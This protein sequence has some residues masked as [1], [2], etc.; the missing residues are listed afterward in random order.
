M[1]IEKTNYD[2]AKS[3]DN[4]TVQIQESHKWEETLMNAFLIMS[5]D[6]QLQILIWD[7]SI[8]R[9]RCEK[10]LV[11][12]IDSKLNFDDH[13]KTLNNSFNN[14]ITYEDL[15][16]AL[17]TVV[18][19]DI[20]RVSGSGESVTYLIAEDP[21][22]VFAPDTQDISRILFSILFNG[23]QKIFLEETNLE[24]MKSTHENTYY[25]W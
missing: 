1:L 8:K 12:K 25:F 18:K 21:D 7:S 20:L 24:H 4:M 9:S 5:T 11:V 6:K 22:S 2:S 19:D 10:L 16:K 17:D 14:S 15:I 23:N 13:V 3:I